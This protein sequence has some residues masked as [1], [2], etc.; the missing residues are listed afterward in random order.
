[1]HAATP[2]PKPGTRQNCRVVLPSEAETELESLETVRREK[3]E[4]GT[5]LLRLDTIA[6]L[7]TWVLSEQ[8]K[9]H[10]DELSAKPFRERKGREGTS[11]YS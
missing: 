2:A 1:M 10:P 7:A 8:L 3:H 11:L 6:K 4:K 5:P 9:P